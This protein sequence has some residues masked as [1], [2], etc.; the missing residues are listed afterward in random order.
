MS[1]LT[2]L[3][4][5]GTEGSTAITDTGSNAKGVT[6]GGA[7]A[8]TIAEK[9]LGTGS[10]KLTTAGRVS[11]GDSDDF[12][13]VN[14]DFEIRGWF[15]LNAIGIDQTVF[16]LKA[17]SNNSIILSVSAANL[18]VLTAQVAGSNW[19]AA[20]SLSSLAA[21]TTGV[22]YYYK[23]KKSSNTLTLLLSVDRVNLVVQQT[24]NTSGSGP[25]GVFLLALGC[26]I[27]S[28][29]ILVEPGISDFNGWMD[30]FSFYRPGTTADTVPETPNSGMF[31]GF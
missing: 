5:N 8:I 14:D 15:R 9:V 4:F 7:A 2:V 30:R 18:L 1:E 23:I 19:G 31:F 20:A 17:A 29:T 13:V 3:E 11:I 26:H 25:T 24:T 12:E 27:N 10:L 28:G 21:L 22:W 6:V 16:Q